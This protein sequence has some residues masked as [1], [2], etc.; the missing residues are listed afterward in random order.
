MTLAEM[1]ERRHT[2]E[3]EWWEPWPA[4]GPEGNE[5]DAHVR[6]T[7]NVHHCV[8][9]QRHARSSAGRPPSGSDVDL[10]ADFISTHWAQP[11]DPPPPNSPWH[12]LRW[13]LE[14]L[15]ATI[16]PHD[17][18]H[19]W[20]GIGNEDLKTSGI[21]LGVCPELDDFLQ[22]SPGGSPVQRETTDQDGTS[23]V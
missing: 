13:F 3:L 16:V 18:Q 19:L 23:L 15:Q 10:L 12:Q 7:A 9:L 17:G 5:L 6:T 4:S 22:N 1:L 14:E 11:V 2:L 8:N 20:I 21:R